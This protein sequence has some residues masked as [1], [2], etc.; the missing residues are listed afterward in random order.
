MHANRNHRARITT[1]ITAHAY[2]AI[3]KAAAMTATT[4]NQFVAQ[5]ALREAERIIEE[6]SIIRLGQNDM[7][8]FVDAL[9]NP[10]P[11]SE[12]LAVSLKQHLE[13][14]QHD[15]GSCRST[16]RWTPKPR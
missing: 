3:E 8:R 9:D 12:R 4:T 10:T 1:R 2:Q 5:A 14:R 13:T 11:I 15:T 16:V 7:K 6:H